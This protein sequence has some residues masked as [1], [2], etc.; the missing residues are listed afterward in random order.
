MLRRTVLSLVNSSHHFLTDS[1]IQLV[2]SGIVW[3]VVFGSAHVQTYKHA[4]QHACMC[5][6]IHTWMGATPEWGKVC[7]YR[8]I[9][10]P[11]QVQIFNFKRET[12]FELWDLERNYPSDMCRGQGHLFFFLLIFSMCCIISADSHT[13][14]NSWSLT[15]AM[16]SSVQAWQNYSRTIRSCG[17]VQRFA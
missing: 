11:W 3:S 16:E 13:S 17:L 12:D 2:C 6:G 8:F 15:G 7:G 1:V 9:R 4:C 10:I 5:A 14:Y